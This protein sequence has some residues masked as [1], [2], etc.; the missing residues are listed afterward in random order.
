MGEK[1]AT[2]GTKRRL[3][4]SGLLVTIAPWLS[5]TYLPVRCSSGPPC[6]PCASDSPRSVTP[7]GTGGIF[8]FSC[9]VEITLIRWHLEKNRSVASD[10]LNQILNSKWVDLFKMA[11]LIK[12]NNEGEKLPMCWRGLDRNLIKGINALTTTQ[13]RLF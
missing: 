9:V 8:L 6:P 13:E 5:H 10:K 11:K 4:I 7:L 2:G 1:H 12:I 3:E